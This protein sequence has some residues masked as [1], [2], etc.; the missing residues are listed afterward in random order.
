MAHM[1]YVFASLV[2]GAFIGGSTLMSGQPAH[3]VNQDLTF[4]ADTYSQ[5]ITAET[6]SPIIVDN[7]ALSADS[8]VGLGF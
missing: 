7:E 3:S 8:V 1:Y 4:K 6:Q 2:V 5:A